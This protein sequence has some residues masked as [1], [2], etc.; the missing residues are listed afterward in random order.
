MA[1]SF[2]KPLPVIKVN[3]AACADVAPQ[4]AELLWVP[5][6][7]LVVDTRYQRDMTVAGQAHVERIAE[8]FDWKKFTP[9]IVSPIGDGLY[10]IIDGQHRA[11]AAKARAFDT[12]PAISQ[13]FADYREAASGFAAINGNVT[14]ISA[15]HVFKAARA[16][17]EGWA[18]TLEKVA[19]EAGVTVLTYPKERKTIQPHETMAIASLRG[20]IAKDPKLAVTALMGIT[21]SRHFGKVGINAYVVKALGAVASELV[22]HWGG[23]PLRFAA[24]LDTVDLPDLVKQSA[25]GAEEAGISR[26]AWLTEVIIDVLRGG[27]A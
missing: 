22:E 5:L 15:L 16:A 4:K 17:G 3:L 7:K 18:E 8:R 10:A 24:M 6:A 20:L 12:V 1:D 26:A 14:P 13:P 23:A 11:A 2:L 19:A 27:E 21:K 25:G 9:L